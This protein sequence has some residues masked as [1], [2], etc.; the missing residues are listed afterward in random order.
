[1]RI[2]APYR[3]SLLCFLELARLIHEWS[4]PQLTFFRALLGALS[5]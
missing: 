2:S 3:A 5:Q 4:A 1:M